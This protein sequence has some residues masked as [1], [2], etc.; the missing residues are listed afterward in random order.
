M[1]PSRLTEGMIDEYVRMEYWDSILISNYW[2]RNAIHHPYKEAI[3][4]E[5]GRLP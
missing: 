2:D 3:L 5:E 4:E 1:K